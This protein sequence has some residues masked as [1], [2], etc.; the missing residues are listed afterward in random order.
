MRVIAVC[1][2]S[3]GDTTTALSTTVCPALTDVTT[4]V[5]TSAGV[6]WGTIARPPRRAIVSAMRRPATAVMFA[7]TT[8]TVVPVPSTLVRSTSKRDGTLER[9]GTRKASP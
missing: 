5:T 2:V 4:S 6:S 3:V 1:T 9:D 8:G 7:T